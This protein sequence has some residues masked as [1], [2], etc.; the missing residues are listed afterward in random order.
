MLGYTKQKNLVYHTENTQFL[1]MTE[2][3]K[4]YWTEL[5][6]TWTSDILSNFNLSVQHLIGI[7]TLFTFQTLCYP[8]FIKCLSIKETIKEFRTEPF[9]LSVE[10]DCSHSM[11]KV[12]LSSSNLVPL[13]YC[14]FCFHYTHCPVQGLNCV[15]K[16][17]NPFSNPLG[18]EIMLSGELWT[19]NLIWLLSMRLLF[20][21][22][23]SLEALLSF[24]SFFSLLTASMLFISMLDLTWM[25]S[26]LAYLLI[27]SAV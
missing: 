10:V 8:A 27:L 20:S 9:I 2:R 6:K 24:L 7:I 12:I 5:N 23:A 22:T 13:S 18:Y 26:N 4:N 1:I 25:S 14:L 16:F 19:L 17:M 11:S 3:V 21:I 15:T